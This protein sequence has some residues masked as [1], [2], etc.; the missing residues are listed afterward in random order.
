MQ[1]EI[2]FRGQRADNGEWIFGYYVKDPMEQH[3]IYWKPF[4]EASSNTYHFV[5]P[6]TI[7]WFTGRIDKN[8]V[9]AF[10]GDIIEEGVVFWDEEHMGFFV[11]GDFTEGRNMPFY[12]IPFI[13]VLGNIHDNPE[14]IQK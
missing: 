3:R 14:L 9:K 6:E 1:R 11:K 10:D 7:G 2:L 12:N 5:I 13:E 4:G 8:N